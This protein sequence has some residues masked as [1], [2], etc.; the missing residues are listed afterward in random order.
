MGKFLERDIDHVLAP[1][2]HRQ[3]FVRLPFDY[4]VELAASRCLGSTSRIDTSGYWNGRHIEMNVAVDELPMAL[5]L[6]DPYRK[7]MGWCA[8]LETKNPHW[9]L[10]MLP[11]EDGYYDLPRDLVSGGRKGHIVPATAE[12]MTFMIFRDPDLRYIG[13]VY[14]VGTRRIEV[15]MYDDNPYMPKGLTPSEEGWIRSYEVGIDRGEYRPFQ[16]FDRWPD[17]PDWQ[18]DGLDRLRN[19]RGALRKRFTTDD[20]EDAA[21]LFGLDPFN[22]DFFTGKVT[23]IEVGIPGDRR[24]TLEQYHQ[25]RRSLTGWIQEEEG[26][27]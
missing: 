20:I 27:L 15:D 13:D 1:F 9:C 21:R 7:G 3:C 26:G 22:R 5:G 11:Y 16:R 2:S 12:C 23:K 6:S 4:A 17:D 25:W 18:F 10:V 19:K 8:V 24:C 14:G